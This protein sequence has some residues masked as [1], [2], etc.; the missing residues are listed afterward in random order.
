MPGSRHVEVALGG[1]VSC[2][3]LWESSH[4]Q[5]RP[6]VSAGWVLAAFVVALL[7]VVLVAVLFGGGPAIPA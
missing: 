4:V 6:H 2:G 5:R 1:G 3:P 7:A